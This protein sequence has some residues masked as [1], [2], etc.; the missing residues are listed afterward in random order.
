MYGFRVSVLEVG[1]PLYPISRLRF[2]DL[3]GRNTLGN[4]CSRLTIRGAQKFGNEFAKKPD[5][6][7]LV[8]CAWWDLRP[9]KGE[10]LILE[11]WRIEM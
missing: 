10:H 7:S 8:T 5:K 1:P 2:Q 3:P 4:L 6:C 9:R 11:E